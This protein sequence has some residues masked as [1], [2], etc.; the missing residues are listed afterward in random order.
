M[1]L[2]VDYNILVMSRIREEVWHARL[3][4][5]VARAIHATATPVT[6]AGL[7]LA[8][9][10]GVA[11]LTGPNDQVKE[12]GL[13]IALGVPLDTF[14]VRTLLVPSTVVLLGR[15]NWWPSKLARRTA[16]AQ[17]PRAARGTADVGDRS[18]RRHG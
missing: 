5:A 3:R 17:I 18:S 2:G 12:L 13:A 9:T 8:A 6:S 4:D 10:F 15:F 7:I 14:L 16:P 1:A 11:G